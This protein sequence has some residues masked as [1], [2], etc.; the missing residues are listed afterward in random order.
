MTDVLVLGAGMAGTAAAADLHRAG[1]SVTIV[2]GRDRIGGRLHSL[3]NLSELP[4]EAGAE[5]I[6]GVGAEHWEVARAAGVQTRPCSNTR[7]V[8]FDAGP[9]PRWLPLVLLHPAVWPSFTI[10]RNIRRHQPPDVSGRE[11]LDRHRY[12]GRA[13]VM[14]QMALTA[15]LPGR[16]DD[17]G[18]L[19]LL[20]DNVLKLETGLNH[21][22]VEGYDTL[23]RFLARDVDVRCGF[24]VASARWESNRVLLTSRSGEEL[25]ARAAVSTLP[26]GV[27]QSGRVQFAPELPESKR[28]ALRA[29]VMGA[30]AKVVV[31]FKERFWPDWMT[32]VACGVGPV[33]LYWAVFHGTPGAP[34]TLIAYAT[35]PRA[36]GLSD[37]GEA[38][39][40]EIVINH[41]RELFP[42]A[43][44]RALLEAHAYV[45]WGRDPFSLGGYTFLRPGGTGAREQL[46]AADT[47]ALFWAG[48]ATATPTIA[49]SVQAAYLSGK[50]AARQVSEFLA[51]GRCSDAHEE[52]RRTT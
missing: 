43:D 25:S 18:I 7:G 35:G 12:R 51:N 31:R 28:A 14:A 32:M 2:E 20:S 5:F 48:S 4:V 23:P 1:L 29:L 16:A 19:G 46:A 17:I 21:R 24:D 52:S 11:F 45:D 40:L 50:R 30:V 37:A 36:Q 8:M 27:L 38:G 34:A 39:A 22:V 41:L 3:R 15:H 26:V 44:V 9:G 13:R 47:G 33:T 42:K 6:H 49:A 10:L